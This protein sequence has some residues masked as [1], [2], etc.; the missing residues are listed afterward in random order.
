M[1]IVSSR[2]SVLWKN[3]FHSW[4]N[5]SL[6]LLSKSKMQKKTKKSEQ[7]FIIKILCKTVRVL[8]NFDKRFMKLTTYSVISKL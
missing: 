7:N 1:L 3:S 2:E 6:A 4:E 8:N 5:R